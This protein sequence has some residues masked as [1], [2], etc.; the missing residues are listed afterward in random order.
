MARPVQMIISDFTCK[1][2]NCIWNTNL[3]IRWRHWQPDNQCGMRAW[4]AWAGDKPVPCIRL[5]AYTFMKFLLDW[6]KDAAV[7]STDTH[8]HTQNTHMHTWWWCAYCIPNLYFVCLFTEG[9]DEQL[10][11]SVVDIM[12]LCLA[13]QWI[14]LRGDHSLITI[15]WL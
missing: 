1:Q 14:L 15:D 12:V 10:R 3:F 2:V 4:G 11:R 6:S 7:Y 8:M 13:R 9:E 5:S